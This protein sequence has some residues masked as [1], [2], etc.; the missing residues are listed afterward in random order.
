MTSSHLSQKR[1][2][3]VCVIRAFNGQNFPESVDSI[4][5]EL[6]REG[7]YDTC[8]HSVQ[9]KHAIQR[10]LVMAALGSSGENDSENTPLSKY[11]GIALERTEPSSPPLAV[12]GCACNGCEPS[13]ICVPDLCQNCVTKP[14]VAACRFDAIHNAGKKSVINVQCCKKCRACLRGC[15]YGAISETVVPCE[16]VCPVDAISKDERG[17]AVI[18]F[19]K[20][21]RCGKCMAACP[22]E[23]IQVRSQVIDVLKA[24]KAK[25]K[26]IALVAPALFGQFRC[27]AGQLH[28]AMKKIG[29]SFVY[30]VAIGAESTSFHEA[31]DLK[32]KLGKGEK[33]MTTSCCAAYNN[34]VS[35]HISEMRPFVSTA[36]T[37]LF[38]TAE[39]V[40]REH[41][42]SVLIFIS[43]CLAKYEEAFANEN[44]GYILNFGEIDA[45]FE[46]FAI[47]AGECAEE[48]F[49]YDSARETREFSLS[50]GV[51]RAVQ[52]VLDGNGTKVEF[53]TI[54][55]LDR[56]TVKDLKRFAKAGECDRGTVLEVMSCQG[57]CV[58]G[59]LT[60]CPVAAATRQVKKYGDDGTS[61]SDKKERGS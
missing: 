58:G 45:L 2:A 18:D 29:F 54:N 35:K 4:L 32:E 46:A 25:K 53:A 28:T 5:N 40:R 3:L 39:Y 43:P 52:S 21:I 59:G 50:G 44:V 27:T 24:I 13:H 15:P 47:V 38:Y 51:S 9:H 11:A 10:A 34:L 7:Y 14:C 19:D 55:G 30:E 20:C 8:Y 41:P 23:A 26:V 31:K 57:G 12:L 37:P 16:H 1:E 6:D 48:K 36:G 49:A 61:L 42:D 22:F 56:E 17:R 60:C 33:F